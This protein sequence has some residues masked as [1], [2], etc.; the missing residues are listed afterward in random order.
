MHII[1][2]KESILRQRKEMEKALRGRYVK[3]DAER[4]IEKGLIKIL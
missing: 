1:M 2:I 4:K 3:R